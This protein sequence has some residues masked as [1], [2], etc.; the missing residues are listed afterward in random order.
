[1]RDEIA[2]CSEKFSGFE[3]CDSNMLKIDLLQ[4]QKNKNEISS[5]IAHLEK[6]QKNVF[7]SHMK[8]NE[9]LDIFQN[10][11]YIY[12]PKRAIATSPIASMT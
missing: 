6:C 11:W 1:M 9:L 4:N 8:K 2:F 10:D 7:A 3:T 5:E 12:M